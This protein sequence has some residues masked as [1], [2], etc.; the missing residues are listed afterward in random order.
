MSLVSSASVTEA[1]TAACSSSTLSFIVSTLAVGFTALVFEKYV[2]SREGSYR[3]TTE[4]MPPGGISIFIQD[5]ITQ[6][7]KSRMT[8]LTVRNDANLCANDINVPKDDCAPGM[9][10]TAGDCANERQRIREI[11]SVRRWGKCANKMISTNEVVHK[12]PARFWHVT[13]SSLTSWPPSDLR[14]DGHVCC[15]TNNIFLKWKHYNIVYSSLCVF[16]FELL[17][18]FIS[19]WAS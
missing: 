15:Q 12:C 2:L 18:V 5:A 10:T 14:C 17:K 7:Y 4:T 11:T 6:R 13:C 19:H 16:S 1:E 8:S 9:K 3:E